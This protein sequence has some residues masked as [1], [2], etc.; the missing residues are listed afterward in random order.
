MRHE[1]DVFLDLKIRAIG[2]NEQGCLSFVLVATAGTNM[3]L[4]CGKKSYSNFSARL[5]DLDED[6]NFRW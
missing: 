3:A 6:I 4:A 5:V 2:Y 1:L